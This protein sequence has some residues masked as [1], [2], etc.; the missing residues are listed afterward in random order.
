LLTPYTDCCFYLFRGS[1]VTA[2]L[3][4]NVNRK[5]ADFEKNTRRIIELLT[6][7]KTKSKQFTK[8]AAQ[9]PSNRSTKKAGLPHA[10]HR[11]A[12]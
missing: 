3:S 4:S 9:K 6:E 12:H 1:C 8:A 7:S 11:K 10:T 2:T 5:S